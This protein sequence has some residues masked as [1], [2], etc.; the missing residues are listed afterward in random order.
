MIISEIFLKNILKLFST[1]FKYINYL[2]LYINYLLFS[3][4]IYLNNVREWVK[5]MEFSS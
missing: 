3:L 2:L 4:F 5:F 1:S